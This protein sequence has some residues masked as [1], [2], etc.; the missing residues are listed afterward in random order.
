MS[1]GPLL[2]NAS[3]TRFQVAP[4]TA[5]GIA[6]SGIEPSAQLGSNSNVPW[7]KLRLAIDSI[8][9]GASGR[10]LRESLLKLF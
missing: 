5:L 7:S 9:S 10:I 2:P 3:L 1:S 6:F 4:S 8:E